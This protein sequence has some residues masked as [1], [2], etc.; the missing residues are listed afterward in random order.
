MTTRIRTNAHALDS[1][2]Q[3]SR[4]IGGALHNFVD[5]LVIAAAFL[6]SVPLGVATAFVVIA[7]EVPQEIGDFAILLESA[8]GGADAAVGAEGCRQSMP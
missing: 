1:W 2:F 6:T 5:G 7:H 3:Q 8:D 4:L